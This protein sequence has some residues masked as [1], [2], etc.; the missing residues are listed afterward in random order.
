MN[1]KTIDPITIPFNVA[2]KKLLKTDVTK[3][4]FYEIPPRMILSIFDVCSDDI[5]CKLP[6]EYRLNPDF[7]RIRSQDRKN[8][9]NSHQRDNVPET[10]NTSQYDNVPESHSSTR[11]PAPTTFAKKRGRFCCI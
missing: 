11:T 10:L 5:W 8:S 3:S 4:E 6:S 9:V 2:P 1:K 7:L